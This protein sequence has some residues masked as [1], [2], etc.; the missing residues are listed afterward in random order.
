MHLHP[1]QMVGDRIRV[2]LLKLL[3]LV[4]NF[5]FREVKELSVVNQFFDEV[6]HRGDVTPQ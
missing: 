5:I 6:I 2:C 4:V 1:T 3:K